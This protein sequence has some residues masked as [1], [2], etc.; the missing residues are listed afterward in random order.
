MVK[1]R[2]VGRDDADSWLRMRRALWPEGAEAE[3][4]EEI[5]AFFGECFPRSPDAVLVAEEKS[6]DGILGVVELAIRAYAEGCRSNRVAYLEGWYV[7]TEARRR[8]V[9]RA[10]VAAAEAWG[11]SMGCREFASDAQLENKASHGA[12]RALGFTDAGGLRC[13]RKD[14]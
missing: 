4:R 10:L 5:E 8:C 2:P 11:R 3:H 1:V 13:F 14:L 7:E 12:H 9:G 6:R